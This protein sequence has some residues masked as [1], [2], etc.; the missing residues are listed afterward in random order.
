MTQLFVAWWVLK[1]GVHRLVVIGASATFL[2][3]LLLWNW[4][5]VSTL[6]WITLGW[7][8]MNL[9]MLK[10]LISLATEQVVLPTARLVSFL[11][12]GASIGTAV[13]PAITSQLVEWTSNH[14]ILMFGSGCYGLLLVLALT[15]LRLSGKGKEAGQV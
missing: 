7:G 2:G 6:T 3:S 10:A 4:S 5:D 9:G 1:I 12:L 13:S 14:V 11:L 8:F 15:A